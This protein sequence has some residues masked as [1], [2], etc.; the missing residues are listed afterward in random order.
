MSKPEELTGFIGTTFTLE[1][2]LTM[3]K[4]GIRQRF[5][6]NQLSARWVGELRLVRNALASLFNLGNSASILNYL[7]QMNRLEF[8]PEDQA[9]ITG[10]VSHYLKL[11][12]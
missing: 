7:N 3:K 11:T 1:E 8:S 9:E 4:S 2:I 12:D 6:K 5:H 10:F